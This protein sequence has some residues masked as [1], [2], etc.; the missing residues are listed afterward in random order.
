MSKKEKKQYDVKRMNIGKT[1]QLDMLAHA[2]GEIYTQ[3]LVSF[4]RVVRKKGIWLKPKHLMRRH[5]S[6][7]LHAHTADACVQAFFASLSSWRERRLVDPKARPPRKRKWYFRIEYKQSAMSLK[8]GILT[9][10]NGRGNAS[11]VLT[12]IY[13]L[14]QTLVIHW[15]GTQYEAIATYT[16][17]ETGKQVPQGDKV[18]GIDLGEIHQA[19]SYD[20]ENTYIVN[21]RLLRSKRQYRN[22]LIAQLDSKIDRLKKGSR[23]RKKLLKSKHNQI[24][25]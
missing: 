5:T 22:K 25:S 4:W 8:N 15:T 14:P 7:K 13:E 2:C 23:R 6:D 11:L 10:S 9:L 17:K 3:T 21:G 24:R 18:A 1:P 19:V 16:H 12:W 20:G